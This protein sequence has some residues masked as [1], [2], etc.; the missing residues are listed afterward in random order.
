MTTLATV[1]P[2]HDVHEAAV[3]PMGPRRAAGVGQ[4]RPVVWFAWGSLAVG[5][6]A[7]V[8]FTTGPHIHVGP[9][10]LIPVVLA[11][12][13]GGRWPGYAVSVLTTVAWMWIGRPVFERADSPRDEAVTMAVRLL[14]YPAMAEVLL[15]LRRI[16]VRLRAAVE[17]Q[18]A[19][20]QREVA[21]RHRAEAALR[22]LAAQLSAAEDAERRRIA[23]DIHDALSQSLGVAKLTLETVVAETAIDARQYPRLTDVVSLIDG[24]IRQTRELT[25]DLHPSMLDH[26]GL[27]PT[28]QQYGQEFTRRTMAE[29]IVTESGEPRKLPTSLAAYLFRSIKEL[30]NNAVKHGNAKEVVAA[31]VWSDVELRVVVDD[32]GAGCDPVE[33]RRPKPGRGLGLAGIDERLTRLGGRLLLESQPGHGT[34]V[35]LEVPAAAWAA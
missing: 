17:R 22:E 9:L 21:D 13:Y 26:F 25:F 29:L 20:L 4:D 12:W 19:E 8:D 18:A 3:G 31:V 11:A 35:I 33:A 23:Y 34:R 14:F 28:L 1:P 24:L 32:D 10:Y 6:V 5:V 15:L 27:V 2:P 7:L 30:L 16:E